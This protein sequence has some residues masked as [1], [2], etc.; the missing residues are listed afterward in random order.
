M[1]Y[2]IAQKGTIRNGEISDEQDNEAK[3]EHLPQKNRSD[4]AQISA[5]G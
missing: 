3:A 5:T 4:K 1:A 2:L